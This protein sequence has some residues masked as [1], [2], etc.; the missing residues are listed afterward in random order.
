MN[1]QTEA[2]TYLNMT[3]VRRINWVSQFLIE[4]KAYDLETIYGREDIGFFAD[5]SGTPESLI[6]H[7]VDALVGDDP[8]YCMLHGSLSRLEIVLVMA[9]REKAEVIK[10][11]DTHADILQ[12]L[13]GINRL[14]QPEYEIRYW[15]E[16]PEG[17]YPLFFPLQKLE[18]DALERWHGKE[19]IQGLFEALTE[20]TFI[21]F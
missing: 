3:D 2:V 17:E 11:S 8:L 21:S 20:K 1:P 6:D 4:A 15:Q 12:I 18:W 7:C 14:I 16:H 19:K 13:L 5:P 10:F 9:Y